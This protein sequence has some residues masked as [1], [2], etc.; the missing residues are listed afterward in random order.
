MLFLASSRLMMSSLA[1]QSLLDGA[2]KT[3]NDKRFKILM[4]S[5]VTYQECISVDLQRYALKNILY[6]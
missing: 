3:F 6:I 2:Q 1:R 4:L 5:I